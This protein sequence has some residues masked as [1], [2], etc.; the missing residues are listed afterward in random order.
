MPTASRWLIEVSLRFSQRYALTSSCSY[1]EPALPHFEPSSPCA[2]PPLAF[3]SHSLPQ[4]L[5]EV[6][7]A[8][9]KDRLVRGSTPR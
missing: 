8:V 6:G 7:L 1:A 9:V 5:R 2:L 4:H 3:L